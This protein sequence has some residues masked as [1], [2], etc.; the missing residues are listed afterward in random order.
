MSKNGFGK[1]GDRPRADV[2]GIPGSEGGGG[3]EVLDGHSV[4]S[5]CQRFGLTSPDLLYNSKREAG[6]RGRGRRRRS[7]GP[8]TELEAELRRVEQEARHPQ[9]K[10]WPLRPRRV[11][12]V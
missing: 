4:A 7:G 2:G 3:T 12:D 11:R 8:R 6:G 5:V 9:K 1:P 10:R